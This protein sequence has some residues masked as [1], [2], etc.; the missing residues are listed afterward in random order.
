MLK[1]QPKGLFVLALAN[2]GERFGYYTM[3]AIFVLYMQAKF[4]YTSDATATTFGIFLSMV[5]FLPLFGGLLA[6]KVLGYGKTIMLGIVVMFAGYFCLAIPSGAGLGAQIAMFG[7]LALIAIGTGC[8][9]GNLQALV[10]NLYDDPK[11]SSKRDIAFSI[12]YMCINIGAFFAPSAAEGVSNYFLGKDGFTYNADIPSLAH[13]LQNGN[14]SSEAMAKFTDMAAQQGYTGTDLAQFGQNYIDSLSQSYN[15]GFGVACLSLIVSM[16][17]FIGFRKYYKAADKTEKQKQAEHNPNVVE[18]TPQ[19]V[20]D[21]L[22]ALGL[23]FAV[24]IFFWMSF[25]QNGLTMTFFARDYTQ[26]S[27]GGI[28]RFG[29]SLLTMIPFIVAFYGLLSLF[30][31]K[32]G[33]GRFGGFVV[34]AVGAVCAWWAYTALPQPMNITPQIFQQFNPFFIIILTPVTVGLFSWLQKRNSEPSAPRKIGIGMIIAALGFIL[35]AFAST[36]LPTPSALE[37]MGGLDEASRVSP[38]WLISTYFVLTIAELFLS[39]MGISFVS[40]VAPPKYKGLAQGGWLAATAVGNYLVAIIGYLW[41]GMSLWM[42][43]GILVVCCAVSAIFL[44]S[45]MKKLERTTKDA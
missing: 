22:V 21:R 36:G 11:Y 15:Y 30:Q 32:N 17:I 45:V 19:Q 14:I 12:F 2:M 4:G 9:K 37:S 3:L 20:K 42:L 41:G 13:Q 23:V 29:F 18:L 33:K 28:D 8:F 44:F 10:G 26:T 5:Y 1:G 25:H 40:K 35:L 34:M 7:S 24:V 27:V 38:N 16:L 6:D 43:W 39:P 31:S